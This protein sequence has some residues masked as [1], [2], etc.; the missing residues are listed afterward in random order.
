M[1]GL[2]YLANLYNY[3]FKDIAEQLGVSKQVV[4]GWIKERYK[5]SRKHLPKLANI[6]NVPEQYFQKE[7][8]ELEKYSIQ[9]NKL[10]NE[11]IKH[12][13]EDTIISEKREKKSVA[14]EFGEDVDIDA[15]R[16]NDIDMKKL[17][18]KNHID[19]AID[20]N[21]S[22]QSPYEFGDIIAIGEY[23]I[24]LYKDF[25]E[26]IMNGNVRLDIIKDII[27]GMND[28]KKDSDEN[29][30]KRSTY[31]KKITREVGREQLKREEKDKMIRQQEQEDFI[32]EEIKRYEEEQKTISEEA[33]ERRKMMDKIFK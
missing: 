24:D 17:S 20:I 16:L 13:G 14:R 7:L 6:F 22:K 25:N 4:N 10:S 23:V 29:P 27:I 26:L 1:I 28:I 15:L 5:I 33:K 3:Q 12:E 9:K 11:S 19:K 2:E 32:N 8:T 30:I 31:T 18:V 21:M